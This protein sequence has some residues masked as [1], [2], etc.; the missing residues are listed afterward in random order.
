VLAETTKAVNFMDDVTSI[1][2]PRSQTGVTPST[3]HQV[4]WGLRSL[5]IGLTIIVIA[6]FAALLYY[7]REIYQVAP[8][9]PD[10]VE[11]SVGDLLF[12][13][14]DV[15]RGQDVWR[16]IGGQEL[17]SVWGHGAYTAPDWTAD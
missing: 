16:S 12:S 5:W 15:L 8:P 10:V 11:T 17:G 1:P 6:S 3:S 14:A 7:G 4:N 13:G 2:E 9:I